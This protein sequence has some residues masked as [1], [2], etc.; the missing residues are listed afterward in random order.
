MPLLLTLKMRRGM[1]KTRRGR[2]IVSRLPATRPSDRWIQYRAEDRIYLLRPICI[3]N[4]LVYVRKNALRCARRSTFID[5]ADLSPFR[6][7]ITIIQLRA[8]HAFSIS[9][10]SGAPFVF[11]IVRIAARDGSGK[12]SNLS[13]R[14]R[15]LHLARTFASL[16]SQTRIT[17][18]PH[19]G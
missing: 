5:R 14:T 6:T 19:N 7:L 2:S 1:R 18:D 17:Y 13:P 3:P 8:P 11:I 12:R 10:V 16:Y 9:F 4:R 15:I